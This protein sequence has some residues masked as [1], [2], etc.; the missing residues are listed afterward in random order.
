MASCPLHSLCRR[1]AST[2]ETGK[3]I[4]WVIIA[5][6]VNLV[7]GLAA[8]QISAIFLSDNA[9]LLWHEVVEVMTMACL[10]FIMVNVG[11]EFKLDK[12]NMQQYAK[13]FAVAM[14]AAFLPS[15]LVALWFL[16]ALPDPLP[17]ALAL[18]SGLFAAATSA[19]ILFSMLEAAGLKETWLYGKAQVLAVFDDLGTLLLLVPLK[20]LVSGFKWELTIEVGMIL[21]MLIL[22]YW[23]LHALPLPHS[24]Q[25]TAL[26]A[27]VVTV[28]CKLTHFITDEHLAMHAIEME[29]LL[30]AFTVG[31][32]V[33]VL[34]E[35]DTI[36][37]PGRT[38]ARKK[39]ER[40]K[41]GISM[42]F[43]ML[44]GL[45]M[46]SLF[47]MDHHREDEHVV[48][49]T[50]SGEEH[51]LGPALLIKHVVVVNLLMTVGKM[52]PT[53]CYRKEADFRTRLALSLGMCPRGEVGAGVIVIALGM[54]MHGTSVTVAVL[55]L[56]VNLMLSSVFIMIVKSLLRR[57]QEEKVAA[58]A[59]DN[60]V[61]LQSQDIHLESQDV[62]DV[63]M[64]G[65]GEKASMEA[66]CHTPTSVK[67]PKASEAATPKS[68]EQ[69]GPSPGQRD[70]YPTL[71]GRVPAVDMI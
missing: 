24:W 15:L 61:A 32:L 45:T 38:A 14:T 22:G 42:V 55:S 6:T 52:F 9:Y 25:W 28:A 34:H 16:Y 44:V 4:P 47:G 17:W 39:E 40:I 70:E 26:Y 7:L 21:A 23:K 64:A 71:L 31:C 41:T 8:S 3:V 49:D 63:H 43:M 33:K 69:L 65:A 2:R 36:T 1:E 67:S 11:Y 56:A 53:C 5:F 50:G 18:L 51:T 68:R 35:D 66:A 20:I 58:P 54:G 57:S 27:L 12:S 60:A 30:P 46:P 59:A 19:G 37:D 13:D 29:V 48:A 10:S 62:Q